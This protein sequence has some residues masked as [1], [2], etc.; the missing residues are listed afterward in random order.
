MCGGIL[1]MEDS[2]FNNEEKDM[3]KG[4]ILQ[5]GICI[6]LVDYLERAFEELGFHI[7]NELKNAL[8]TRIDEDNVKKVRYGM[9]ELVELKILRHNQNSYGVFTLNFF[10]P[11]YLKN[12]EKREWLFGE[13][14]FSYCF[15]N[16]VLKISMDGETTPTVLTIKNK[17]DVFVFL[18]QFLEKKQ[19]EFIEM[20]E[21]FIKM[22]N[23]ALEMN[24]DNYV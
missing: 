15:D 13:T 20:K 19:L 23:D 14:L 10:N 21:K 11:F 12:D 24:G 22:S 8:E 4:L 2:Y 18:D 7:N 1:K 5:H 3:L 16:Y 6:S 9:Q 17:K